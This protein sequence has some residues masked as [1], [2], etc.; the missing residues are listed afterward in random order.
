M[1]TIQKIGYSLL[2]LTATASTALAAGGDPFNSKTVTMNTSKNT[3]D[4]T[5]Q[6][7]INNFL[8]FLSIVAVAYGIY[9]GFLMVTAGGEEDKMKKGRT[10]L[11]QVAIGIIVIWVAGSLVNWI[12]RLI[13]PNT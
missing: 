11:L 1:N 7:I 6:A 12:I 3:A 10:I 13:I 4:Q 2:G 5:A 9:G 8:I